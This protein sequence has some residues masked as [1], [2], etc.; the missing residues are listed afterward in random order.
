MTGLISRVET[1]FTFAAL[2]Q[3]IVTGRGTP[4]CLDI[5]H[6][7]SSDDDDDDDDGDNDDDDDISLIEQHVA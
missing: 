4:S 5:C 7:F 1:C 2:L 3:L 6:L